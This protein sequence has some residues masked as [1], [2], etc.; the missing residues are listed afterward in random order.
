MQK[1]MEYFSR[2]LEPHYFQ[3]A[4]WIW[5][6]LTNQS[7]SFNNRPLVHTWEL[8]DKAFGFERVRKYQFVQENMDM[9]QHFEDNLN[10]NI[11]NQKNLQ[12]FLRVAVTVHKNFKEKYGSN[13]GFDDPADTDPYEEKDE[14]T[15]EDLG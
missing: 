4:L 10:L 8:Y 6:N 11:S 14:K 2:K 5:G 1:Q 12:N 9:L 3:N 15:W 13:G 7:A